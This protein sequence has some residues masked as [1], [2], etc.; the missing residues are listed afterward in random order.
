[1]SSTTSTTTTSAPSCAGNSSKENEAPIISKDTPS[2]LTQSD[3]TVPQVPLAD[4][5]TWNPEEE[6]SFKLWLMSKRQKPEFKDL[7]NLGFCQPPLRDAGLTS[8]PL[9]RRCETVVPS[10]PLRKRL[11]PSSLGTIEDSQLSLGLS[12]DNSGGMSG[13][14]TLQ[15]PQGQANRRLF[16]TS[17]AQVM[18]TLSQASTLFGSTAMRRSVYSSLTSL[19]RVLTK[20]LS[21]ESWTAIRTELLSKEAFN[22]LGGLA[23]LLSGITGSS[24]ASLQSYNAGSV[25]GGGSAASAAAT[26]SVR[27][28]SRAGASR[29]TALYLSSSEEEECSSDHDTDCECEDCLFIDDDEESSDYEVCDDGCVDDGAPCA[30]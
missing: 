27:S 5:P 23:S 21:S 10:A 28:G 12:Q 14:S 1:M 29:E 15:G 30:E 6:A 18:Y 17:S 2:S 9:L 20:K 7:G 24:T 16:T 26:R 11:R 19:K 8:T 13:A 4:V 25:P 22:K 3:S